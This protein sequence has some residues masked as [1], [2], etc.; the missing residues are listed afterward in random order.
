VSVLSRIILAATLFVIAWPGNAQDN[1]AARNLASNYQLADAAGERKCAI[2]LETKPAPG[3]FAIGF[4]REICGL[5]FSF[6]ADVR[7][8]QPAPAGGINLVNAKGTAITEFTEGVGGV[9][10]A[11]R[12]NDG[13]YFLS[14][15]KIADTKEI[16]PADLLGEW[17]L[18]RPGGAT[19][20]RIALTNEVVGDSRF[21]IRIAPGCDS[22]I[23]AFGPATW[24]LSSGDV[25][26][27][28]KNGDII[29]LG[30]NEEGVWSR[31]PDQKVS[32]PRPLLM[33]R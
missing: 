5:V 23:T 7:A 1:T 16:Q 29:R 21:I 25:L 27:F 32:R 28:S 20:C 8:W 10:E 2:V 30:K 24:Q 33:T 6:L 12:D 31:V 13:V 14:N 18:S 22:T 26:L 3:G 19:I 4:D 9:Y 15:L 11:I 17:S